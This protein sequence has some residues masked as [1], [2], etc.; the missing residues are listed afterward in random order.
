MFGFH[1]SAHVAQNR[2]EMR[3]MCMELNRLGEV[4]GLH[5]EQ[6]QI[7]P[8][9]KKDDAGTAADAPATQGNEQGQ[10]AVMSKCE[11]ILRQIPAEPFNM[12]LIW[13]MF[14]ISGEEP[15]NSV[16]VQEVQ[17]YQPLLRL[18]VSSINSVLQTIK[19]EE[20]A[21]QETEKLTEAL[22]IGEVPELWAKRS[23]PTER[24]LSGFILDFRKRIATLEA[25]IERGTPP[26][27]FW[28]PGF[29]FPHS[30]LTA[31]LQTYAARNFIPVNTLTHKFDY[32]VAVVD[33]IDEGANAAVDLP[34]F[35]EGAYVSGL[36][37]EGAS[38]SLR[39]KHL[40]DQAAEEST[41]KMP[42]LRLQPIV[43]GGE[44]DTEYS[45]DSGIYD[46][47]V[48]RSPARRG[49]LS[50]TG[51]STNFVMYVGLPCGD[52]IKARSW[53]KR[54]AALLCEPPE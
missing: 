5:A 9:D 19:G 39:G 28:L 40:V 52:G 18:I 21:S 36:Y 34:D 17:R 41:F 44:R 51:H 13:K 15:Y 2:R 24:S 11:E 33:E 10:Y 49:V 22:L 32:T 42:I 14:P 53:I 46:C 29:Y 7:A 25:W 43:A 38:W 37:L 8:A 27:V 3:Q 50:T 54:G 48:Y 12:R 31:T 26:K 47:P 45:L 30:F 16:L 35:P 23:Y 1:T 6:I 20:V 4:E